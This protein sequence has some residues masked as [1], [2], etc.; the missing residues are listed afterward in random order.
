MKEYWKMLKRGLAM[1]LAVV[2]LLTSSNLGV[3]LRAA[4]TG[5]DDPN[6]VS[7]SLSEIVLDIYGDKLSDNL[8]KIIESGA[9]NV[10][11]TF[12]YTAPTGEDDL[13]EV[14]EVNKKI[15]AEVFSDG[16]QN[17]F[18]VAYRL[19]VDEA[20]VEN[21]EMVAE[22]GVAEATY[23]YSGNAFSVEVDYEA[24]VTLDTLQQ[25][26]LLSSGEKLAADIETLLL[27]KE[28][29]IP[30][31]PE[32]WETTPEEDRVAVFGQEVCDEVAEYETLQA[33]I[34]EALK[35]IP[36][37][38]GLELNP[39]IVLMF[40]TQKVL[41]FNGEKDKSAID[42]LGTLG[43]GIT[44]VIGNEDGLGDLADVMLDEYPDVF[45]YDRKTGDIYVELKIKD[46]FPSTANQDALESLVAQG[47]DG[48]LLSQYLS[49]NS[50]KSYLEWLMVTYDALK[51]AVEGNYEDLNQLAT[52]G[53]P[54]M[55]SDMLR[56]QVAV[57]GVEKAAWDL[58]AETA[59][60]YGLE[61]TKDNGK[62]EYYTDEV[63]GFDRLLADYAE[64]K[65]QETGKS[66]NDQ[67]AELEQSLK[68][69][70]PEG[71]ESYVPDLPVTKITCED[72]LD[73]LIKYVDDVE[74]KLNTALNHIYG[75]IDDA[76]AAYDVDTVRDADDV[77][78]A[79][80]KLNKDITNA[81][82]EI[83]KIQ[84]AVASLVGKPAAEVTYAD[85]VNKIAELKGNVDTSSLKPYD[86]AVANAWASA[87]DM[88]KGW[89]YPD[90]K[91]I[92]RGAN[93][94]VFTA[95]EAWLDAQPAAAQAA[96]AKV[97]AD[98]DAA[99]AEMLP[100][101]VELPEDYQKIDSA[102]EFGEFRQWIADYLED[103][104]TE[105]ANGLAEI[106][107][108]VAEANDKINSEYGDFGV[109]LYTGENLKSE[110][111]LDQIKAKIAGIRSWMNGLKNTI[112][113]KKAEALAKAEEYGVDLTASNA[114]ADAMEKA[115][116]EADEAAA[117][118]IADLYPAAYDVANEELAK[119]NTDLSMAT[120]GYSR[121]TKAEDV[122]AA[123]EDA[124]D[125]TAEAAVWAA[126]NKELPEQYRV[127][128]VK[129]AQDHIATLD[130][131]LAVNA[132]SQEQYDAIAGPLNSAIQGVNAIQT[133]LIP[134][135]EEAKTELA[136][137]VD[138]I[139]KT[140]EDELAKLE[141]DLKE[142]KDLLD[143]ADEALVM[144][145]DYAALV[146][147]DSEKLKTLYDD[148][149]LIDEADNALTTNASDLDKL[150]NKLAEEE[151]K[152]NAW[153]DVSGKKT[154]LANKKTAIVNAQA[155]YEAK[156]KELNADIAA[157]ISILETQQAAWDQELAKIEKANNGIA[158]VNGQKDN[159]DKAA[160][161]QDMQKQVAGYDLASAKT[162][163]QDAYASLLELPDY[164]DLLAETKKE[165]VTNIDMLNI[166]ITM[167]ELLC[168]K[169]DPIYANCKNETWNARNILKTSGVD[170]KALS[171]LVYA[172]DEFQDVSNSVEDR[173]TKY[174]LPTATV[175]YKMSM[176]DVKVVV[177]AEA[178]NENNELVELENSYNAGKKT[179]VAG[180]SK[181]DIQAVI[182]ELYSGN[183]DAQAAAIESFVDQ[184]ELFN[185]EYFSYNVVVKNDKGDVIDMPETL[186]KNLT[187]ELVYRPSMVSVSSEVDELNSWMTYGYNLTL[188]EHDNAQ[189]EWEYTVVMNGKTTNP[190]QGETVKILG[191]TTISR[192]EGDKSATELVEDI[193]I[194]T[195]DLDEIAQAILKS[196]AVKLNDFIYIR[197]PNN[198]HLKK[199]TEGNKVT[200]TAL[201]YNSGAYG[202]WV[203]VSAAIDGVP[204]DVVNGI[205]ETEEAFDK[206]VVN[207]ELAL[208]SE[209]LG[210]DLGKYI[211]A[212]YELAADYNEQKTAL[213]ALVDAVTV[214]TNSDNVAA[215]LEALGMLDRSTEMM[216][217]K[218][219]DVFTLLQSGQSDMIKGVI[220]DQLGVTED[221]ADQLLAALAEMDDPTILPASGKTPLYYSLDSYNKQGM[222]HYYKNASAYIKQIE[223]LNAVMQMMPVDALVKLG[224]VGNAFK[225]LYDALGTAETKLKAYPVSDLINV[226]SDGLATLLDNLDKYD[227]SEPFAVPSAL[228]WKIDL[229]ATG[230][231][232]E[233]HQVTVNVQGF[234]TKTSAVITVKPGQA[235]DHATE[236][237]NIFNGMVEESIRKYFTD[238]EVSTEV[239]E[240]GTVNHIYTYNRETYNVNVPGVGTVT[241]NYLEREITLVR[242]ET[243]GFAWVYDVPGES[244]E[245]RHSASEDRKYT[246][247]L[248]QLDDLIAGAEITRTAVNVG[249]ADLIATI[250]GMGG[251]LY[252]DADGKYCVVVGIDMNNTESL[253]GF[254][255][256]LYTNGNVQLGGKT[257]VS[258]GQ[259]HLQT[260]VDT[261][262]NSG[263]STNMLNA[264]IAADGTVKNTLV[265]PEGLT[266]VG[267]KALSG[268]HLTLI[269]TDLTLKD[270]EAMPLYLTLTGNAS[271]VKGIVSK[272]GNIT[273]A[274]QTF[275]L[276]AVLS[277][278]AA[279]ASVEIPDTFY[280][281]YVAALSMVGEVD[282]RDVN[283]VNAQVAVGY[284][285]SMIQDL[286]K[287][288]GVTV[289]SFGN[290]IGKDLSSYEE[291][292]NIAK[293]LM[294]KVEYSEDG[295]SVLL[296][297]ENVAINAIIDKAFASIELPEQFKEMP[298]GDLIYEYDPAIGLDIKAGL[299]V[300]NFGKT[301]LAL[302][303]DHDAAGL[304]NKIKVYTTNDLKNNT[305]TVNGTA[306]I[307]LSNVEN[308][309]VNANVLDL[310]GMDVVNLTGNGSVI[311]TDSDYIAAEPARVSGTVSKIGTILGGKFDT[312]VSAY[313]DGGYTQG[314]NGVVYNKL[315]KTESD[316]ANVVVTLNA[317]PTE[318][319]ALASKQGLIDIAAEIAASLVV[320]HYNMASLYVDGLKIYDI[321][322]NDLVGLALGT[323]RLNKAI[324]TV[325]GCVSASDL[326][327]LVNKLVADLTD[328]AAIE[329]ALN[330]GTEI[331]TYETSTAAWALTPVY[332]SDDDTVTLNIGA[333]E[334]KTGSLSI[335]VEGSHAS[336]LA[337]LAGALADT[338]KVDV[339]V[340]MDDIVRNGRVFQVTGAF[341]GYVE[342]NF[343]HDPY[344]AIMMAVIL[345]D[346]ADADLKADLVDAIEAYFTSSEYS[347]EALEEVFNGLS[348]K[349]ICSSLEK[350]GRGDLFADIVNSLDLSAEVKEAI[351]ENIDYSE[352]K[353]DLVIDMIAF[354]LRQLSER[355][356]G[357]SI[358]GS[359]K[360]L[361]GILKQDENGKN[362]YG[363][364]RNGSASGNR[365][366]VRGYS[367]G[368]DL[369]VENIEL[370]VYLFGE[371]ECVFDQKIVAPEYLMSEATHEE[372]AKYYYSCICGKSSKGITNEWFYYGEP[373]PTIEIDADQIK[374]GGNL[375]GVKYDEGNGYLIL[376]TIADGMT[377]A[378]ILAALHQGA[379][380]E[381][382]SDDAAAY[383]KEK[384]NV[385]GKDDLV[386]TGSTIT[387]QAKN[388]DGVTAEV[389]VTII[390]L[391]DTN[392]DGVLN[393]GDAVLMHN[394][395]LHREAAEL[396]QVQKLAGNANG[397]AS[398]QFSRDGIDSGD[399]VVVMNKWLNRYVPGK[400]GTY[401]SPLEN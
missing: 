48:L 100:D 97:L 232:I 364:A 170:Y 168:E 311:V 229:A 365:F 78:A 241:L 140:K 398:E 371:H 72:D 221:V 71:Y 292:Y 89:G 31:K 271:S 175:E 148:K 55:V 129:G 141:A 24:T 18:P 352:K 206:I 124:N 238:A 355:D 196:N 155:T 324:D 112:S 305:L 50:S 326:A 381:N 96:Y 273:V 147:E 8:K 163:A 1:A 188:P 61:I 278:G 224:G 161:I 356:L 167:L 230:D 339:T 199:V 160:T 21:G 329:N 227:Q 285:V 293:G 59:G 289:N 113:T 77:T 279:K 304:M 53:L 392:C 347:M 245:M 144:I 52:S 117:K 106:N 316:G 357:E 153:Q 388:G 299:E 260:L 118:A 108:K 56:L 314:S 159:L 400:L 215:P 237:G 92:V 204:I 68:N 387:L 44:T 122:D 344:Y 42:L 303:V 180:V 65:D 51:K 197:K 54:G 349:D 397:M 276:D 93:M 201:P 270:L 143:K 115:R 258:N 218:L 64:V 156:L 374:I 226:N 354:A 127:T 265:L 116:A 217:F 120:F 310:N 67:L 319:A 23:A 240:D 182:D 35:S 379:E 330:N 300:K 166:L 37:M 36:G 104:K 327:E 41:E 383:V 263:I 194:A 333:G 12:T 393:S 243:V 25:N 235:F 244:V 395:V 181:A 256:G 62:L 15:T 277:D 70:V 80:N 302:A 169:I 296:N 313:L 101:G 3:V 165:L 363:A 119:I 269:E 325:L 351:N 219:A 253:M 32:G 252:K 272:L 203:A 332:Q 95:L 2:M 353:F 236:A 261:L 321:Q 308:L 382:D 234:G 378:D 179:L 264:N 345:A 267:N 288:S 372:A 58:I 287:I 84:A 338:T 193:V 90:Y 373:L 46:Q 205:I 94:S 173:V 152:R 154:E 172:N 157:D 384:S 248:A 369:T 336:E 126:F 212:P 4:A 146:S 137:A 213:D 102:A 262:L 348:V 43:E 394:Y 6:A 17:W 34:D 391:G 69:D 401:D 283:A 125:G 360:T 39:Q 103:A 27:L 320:N 195:T 187:V 389:T 375:Y 63:E 386:G 49:E 158:A 254:V 98:V 138:E 82:S 202:D 250:E 361:G 247:S 73:A 246:L 99:I 294:N 268:N 91:Q 130:G 331:V 380:V 323:D 368:Y 350:H 142:K 85:I 291:I 178:V 10:T 33:Y 57:E 133:D 358:T 14:D 390:V 22:H 312:N 239:T 280:A 341:D 275:T 233:L 123:I 149:A 83:G 87:Q 11:Q 223:Q 284:F 145:E 121:W 174:T 207:Y 228:T 255:L 251:V 220:V 88:A 186:D 183:S 377:L 185:T 274:G 107:T 343:A 150:E 396:T 362:Y 257:L 192:K 376:D 86:D 79:I 19:V 359:S 45:K 131:L 74:G 110:D 282:I 225:A 216:G 16:E 328:F 301:Y 136:D 38:A 366:N 266:A 114:V 286:M 242:H 28:N 198:N 134:A 20:T 132:V 385:V 322:V 231:G 290:T 189:K 249:E 346:N 151:A 210:V 211:N 315:F 335:K 26:K 9:V 109:T 399:A 105:Y 367:L 164:L 297:L 309:V 40:M 7:V 281:G 340:S 177:K 139:N 29:I 222:A 75:E 318:I 13:I 214:D 295:N 306:V 128:S 190:R 200:I 342:I 60:E 259:F 176:F 76:L 135:L 370:R 184:Y 162:A 30:E 191:E 66:L 171:E 111:S 47:E 81:Q 298:L 5:T 317:T 209:A 337:G 208:T 307:L 334:L